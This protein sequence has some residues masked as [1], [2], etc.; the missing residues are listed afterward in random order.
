MPTLVLAT[1]NPGKVAE[2]RALLGSHLDLSRVTLATP[3][4]LGLTLAPIAETG[5]TFAE[6]ARIKAVALARAADCVALAD[7]SGLC[8]DAL[9]GAPGLHSARWAGEATSEADRTALLLE[10]LAAVPGAKR[11]ARFVCAVA[12][13]FP[14]GRVF[15]EEGACEGVISD[16]P[17]GSQGFGYDPVFLIPDLGRTF[18]ELNAAEKDAISHR[19][20]ALGA[21]APTLRRLLPPRV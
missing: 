1:T 3:R 2:F 13:A 17:R 16:A 8:V 19:A 6:N 4:E 11:T 10:R 21:L 7:D 18:A 20:Q 5:G 9:E 15:A 12:L 14:D